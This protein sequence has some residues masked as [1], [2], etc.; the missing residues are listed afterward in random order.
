MTE[1]WNNQN[2]NDFSLSIQFD[3]QNET[4]LDV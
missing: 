2:M 4:T 3:S 1:F